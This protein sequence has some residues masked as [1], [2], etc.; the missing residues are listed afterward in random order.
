MNYQRYRFYFPLITLLIL[1][2]FQ[3]INHSISTIHGQINIPDIIFIG[4]NILTMEDDAEVYDAVAVIGDKISAVGISEELLQL[5]GPTTLIY[6]L[7]ER[8]LLPGFIDSHTHWIGDRVHYGIEVMNE[9][10]DLA[11]SYGWTS[12]SEL[13]VNEDRITELISLANSNLLKIRVNTYLPVSWMDE[14]F[15]DWYQA[16]APEHEYSSYLRIAGVKLFLD[17]GPGIGYIGRSYWFEQEELDTLILKLHNEGY[18]IAIHGIVD[19]STDRALNSLELALGNGG[20]RDYRHRIE[21]AIM[22]RDDQ[23]QLMADK[24]ILVS[25]QISWATSDWTDEILFDPGPENAHLV[26]RW[27]D[28]LDAG[29][30]AIGGTDYPWDLYDPTGSAMKGIYRLVTR[31][32]DQGFEP[33]EWMLAQRITI[34]E[35]LN[36]ITISAAFGTFQEDV[37]GSIKEGKFADFVVLSENPI[38]DDP[39]KLLSIDVEMTMIGGKVE[40]CITDITAFCDAVQYSEFTGSSSKNS[41]SSETRASTSLSLILI[42]PLTVFRKSRKTKY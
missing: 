5:A 25:L 29:I 41:S 17:N 4:D 15:G 24:G 37:K 21:H 36:L 39:E 26:S 31:I 7:K 28:V 2:N 33:P 42:Y 40:H 6:D 20:N 27:R 22:L 35:A 13:F 3:P 19:N 11:I 14:R 23:L 1:L 10:I 34:E 9:A 38:V 30:P 32:G 12:I 8:A 16:Y 18:Q